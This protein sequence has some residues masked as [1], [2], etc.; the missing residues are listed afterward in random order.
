M[1]RSRT[2]RRPWL[3][4]L[5]A[6]LSLP[7]TSG[8][9]FFRQFLNDPMSVGAVV[10]T[11]RAAIDGL[12]RDVDWSRCRLFVE[13]GPGTGAFTRRVLELAR[14]D[15]RV[16]GIDPNP[17]FVDHLRR[18]LPDPRLTV[19]QGS[20][21]DIEAILAAHGA[22]K[23]DYI[24][25][26]LPF[27]TLPDGMAETIVDATERALEPGGAFLVYQ[28]SLFVLPMLK[29]RFAQIAVDRVW[30]CIPPAR[31]MRASKSER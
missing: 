17:C 21:A 6:Q 16:I 25:S 18:S 12:L 7:A 19:V 31:L 9:L 3:D 30:L 13:Y 11:S 27:S 28:Y 15:A 10:P 2:E 4:R 29:A 14:P 23:A 26:G 8:L 5:Q 24:L 22:Q 1:N 20:A